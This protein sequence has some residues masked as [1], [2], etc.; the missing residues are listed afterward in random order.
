MP[1]KDSKPKAAAGGAA[2]K[3]VKSSGKEVKKAPA[4]SN[5]LFQSRP[6]NLRVGGDIR[7]R[8]AL[9]SYRLAVNVPQ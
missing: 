6:K 9:F 5:P 3:A 1:P 7:V 2:K 4:P 8:Y